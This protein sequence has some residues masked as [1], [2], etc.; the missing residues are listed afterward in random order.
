MKIPGLDGLLKGFK[1]N[2]TSLLQGFTRPQVDTRLTAA[3]PGVV[4]RLDRDGM[5]FAGQ[6]GAEGKKLV[7][8]SAIYLL[9]KGV[10]VEVLKSINLPLPNLPIVPSLPGATR[11]ANPIAD[12]I[13]DRQKGKIVPIVLAKYPESALDTSAELVPLVKEEILRLMF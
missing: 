11:L 4:A 2:P 6:A 5:N 3:I 7:I 1:L 12:Y 8:R 13:R 10:W 9:W